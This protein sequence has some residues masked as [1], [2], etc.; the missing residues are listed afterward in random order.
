MEVNFLSSSTMVN[1]KDRV[2]EG[3]DRFLWFSGFWIDKVY[4]YLLTSGTRAHLVCQAILA[5]SS[6]PYPNMGDYKG[7]T[8]LSPP[9]AYASTMG[10]EANE[11]N[12]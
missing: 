11:G 6:T 8:R 7:W 3:R 2:G 12:M 1:T 4:L 9:T 10:Y 5:Y